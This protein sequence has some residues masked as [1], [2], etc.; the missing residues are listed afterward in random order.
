MSTI[1]IIINQFLVFLVMKKK[2]FGLFL[3]TA[4]LFSVGTLE[5]CKD[6]DSDLYNEVLIKGNQQYTELKGKITALRNIAGRCY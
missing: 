4:A 6:N 2:F 3:V 1:N 5:S